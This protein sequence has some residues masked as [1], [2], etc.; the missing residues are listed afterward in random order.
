MEARKF[1]LQLWMLPKRIGI[2]V[3]VWGDVEDIRETLS[4]VQHEDDR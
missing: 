2:S 4:S 1:R 3:R